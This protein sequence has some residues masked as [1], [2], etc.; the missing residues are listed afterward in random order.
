MLKLGALAALAA[1]AGTGAYLN[2][3]RYGVSRHSIGLRG[4]QEPLRLAQ[5][6]DLHYGPFLDENAVSDWVSSTMALNADAIVLTGDFIDSRSKRD[7]APF[8]TTLLQLSAPLGVWVVWGNHDHIS[9]SRLQLLNAAFTEAGYG[10]LTNRNARLRDDLLIA[11][12]DDYRLGS[13]DLG[14]ALQGRE[15][16]LPVVLLSHNPD[17]LPGL[18]PGSVDLALC[19]H[20]HGGQI[21]LP[22]VGPLVTGSR[23][24]QRFA[25]GWVDAPVPAYVSRGLGVSGLPLRAFC[26]PELTVVDLVPA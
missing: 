17:V 2:I 16:G 24:G 21:S 4:L 19:G 18:Q 10:I 15:A 8:L 7:P 12:I 6:S 25:E 22:L 11:G 20:T 1:L 26:P 23:Y 14:A 3:F 9:R 13:P 5:L